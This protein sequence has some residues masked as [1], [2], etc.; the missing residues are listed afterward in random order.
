M[1]YRKMTLEAFGE[2]LI[3]SRDLDPVYCL[4]TDNSLSLNRQ[5]RLLLAYFMFYDIGTASEISSHT[6]AAFW[7]EATSKFK[8]WRRGAERRHFRGEAGLRAVYELS[9][10]F[11]NPDAAVE[12]LLAGGTFESVMSRIQE[13]RGFGGW[14]AWKA[15]DILER[16]GYP[17]ASAKAIPP[18]YE[19]PRKGAKLYAP[20]APFEETVE[21]LN[22][23]FKRLEAPPRYDRPCGVQEV[24]TVLC[25]W[26]SHMNGHYPLGKDTRELGESIGRNIYSYKLFGKWRDQQYNPYSFF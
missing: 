14:I 4:F 9:E 2:G 21:K 16:T 12:Y 5:N 7:H 25:K 11:P 6:D 17:I 10:R 15:G 8:F 22:A 19:E 26:K 23:Y 1:K 18:M 20:D 13:W 3:V 24:E